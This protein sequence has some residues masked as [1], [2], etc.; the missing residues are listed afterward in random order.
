ML[1]LC[2]SNRSVETIAGELAQTY[3]APVDRILTDIIPMLQDL[4]DKGVV[5]A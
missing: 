4:A 3:S 1:R 5:T 2:D